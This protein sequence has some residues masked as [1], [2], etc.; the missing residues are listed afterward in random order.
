VIQEKPEYREIVNK[1]LIRFNWLFKQLII[2][3]DPHGRN[4]PKLD[5][6]LYK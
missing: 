5:E 6:I 1:R 2:P 4:G 3:E